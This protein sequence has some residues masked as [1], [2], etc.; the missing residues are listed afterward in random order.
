MIALANMHRSRLLPM[1]VTHMEEELRTNW[2][3]LSLCLPKMYLCVL[4]FPV[5]VWFMFLEKKK[6][7]REVWDHKS[8]QR[9]LHLIYCV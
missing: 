9:H 6:K 2:I 3:P 5:K 1:V 4:R 8:K 7:K